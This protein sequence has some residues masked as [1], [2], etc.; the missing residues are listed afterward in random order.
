ME[1]AHTDCAMPDN[2]IDPDTVHVSDCEHNPLTEPFDS[3]TDTYAELSLPCGEIAYRITGTTCE[4]EHLD[5]SDD[6]SGCGV[7]KALLAR[8]E[9]DMVEYA[10]ENNMRA[11][12]INVQVG[13]GENGTQGFFEH[14]GYTGKTRQMWR[15]SPHGK[16]FV[17]E[18]ILRF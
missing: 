18:K 5:V 6:Y 10:T 8:L 11:I 12:T 7:G 2:A 17:G 14:L 3:R 4:L 1:T 9:L 16:S 15:D 13:N